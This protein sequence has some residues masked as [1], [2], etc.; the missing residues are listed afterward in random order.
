MVGN[1]YQHNLASIENV[2]YYLSYKSIKII[3]LKLVLLDKYL[4]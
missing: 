3:K 1:L 4:F 2:L